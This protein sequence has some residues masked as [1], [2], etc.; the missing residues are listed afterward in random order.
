MA[1]PGAGRTRALQMVRWPLLVFH[2]L[3]MICYFPLLV[4]KGSYHYW[5]FFSRWF[6]EMTAVG[7]GKTARMSIFESK[8]VGMLC[9][10]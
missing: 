9:G 2:L 6:E 4:L 1:A 7:R 3:E 8:G 5:D 10:G